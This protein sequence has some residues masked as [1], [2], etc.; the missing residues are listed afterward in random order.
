MVLQ[1]K[2]EMH[3][4]LGVDMLQTLLLDANIHF[5]LQSFHLHARKTMYG[6]EVQGLLLALLAC[7]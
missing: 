2:A 7:R 5:A 4:H 6:V 3:T 1:Q